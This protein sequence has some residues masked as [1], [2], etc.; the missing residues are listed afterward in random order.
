M[1]VYKNHAFIYFLRP[2][3]WSGTPTMGPGSL[4]FPVASLFPTVFRS[5]ITTKSASLLCS[6]R[7][8]LLSVCWGHANITVPTWGDNRIQLQLAV[9]FSGHNFICSELYLYNSHVVFALWVY[10]PTLRLFIASVRNVFSNLILSYFIIP[11]VI[12][13]HSHQLVP[14]KANLLISGLTK[15]LADS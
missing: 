14:T 5:S 10:Q 12:L 7:Y 9:C 1:C 2:P 13:C 4:V 6:C 8:P 3:S 11:C 15:K